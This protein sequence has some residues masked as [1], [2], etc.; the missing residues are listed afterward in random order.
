[1]FKVTGLVTNFGHFY[2]FIKFWKLKTLHDQEYCNV[3]KEL[4]KFASIE[5]LP[6]Y[7][8]TPLE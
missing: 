3:T 8:F 5:A 4:W 6:E 1:M 2:R 7:D